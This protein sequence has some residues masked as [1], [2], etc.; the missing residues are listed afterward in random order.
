MKSESAARRQRR[1]QSTN[2]RDFGMKHGTNTFDYKRENL[3]LL[4]R[5]SLTT[6]FLSEAGRR[7]LEEFAAVAKQSG[8]FSVVR[9]KRLAPSGDPHDYVS[10]AAYFWP[11]PD[12]EDGLPWVMRDGEVNP[13]RDEGD[14]IPLFRFSQNVRLLCLGRHLLADE[15]C[16]SHADR[17]LRRWFLDE[18]TRM[19]PH[20]SYAQYVPGLADGRCWGLID[21]TPLPGMLDAI[22]LIDSHL[23]PDL[24]DGLR[25]WFDAF[26]T[27]FTSSNLGVEEAAMPNNHA[28]WH[29]VQSASYLAFAGR[30][31]EARDRLAS[32]AEALILDQVAEDGRQEHELKRT[33]SFGYVNYNL[34]AFLTLAEQAQRLGV[35]LGAAFG[36]RL[37]AAC[38]FLLPCAAGERWPFPMIKPLEL[39]T[40]IPVF[41]HAHRHCGDERFREAADRLVVSEGWDRSY[42]KLLFSRA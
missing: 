25:D 12:T 18:A 16:A 19:N 30:T 21:T 40:M 22:R 3:L 15:A 24:L 10:L 39:D 2:E 23:A 4:D 26:A 42:L 31:E 27:W 35:D 41:H 20:L 37:H 33:L 14:C 8:P 13:E 36:E 32:R 11:N 1:R 34:A 5:T 28:T 9:G 29:L 6:G 7:E 38:A 17:L